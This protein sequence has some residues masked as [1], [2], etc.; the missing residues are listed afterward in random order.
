MKALIFTLALLYL[1]ILGHSQTEVHSPDPEDAESFE[2]HRTSPPKSELI[3]GELNDQAMPPSVPGL[4][5][6]KFCPIRVNEMNLYSYDESQMSGPS[7]WG[8]LNEMFKICEDGKLQ[9]PIN[10]ETDIRTLGKRCG[11]KLYLREGPMRL[12]GLVGNWAFE[13]LEI[14]GCGW[15]DF[16]GRQ[17]MMDSIRFH[18]PSEHYMNGVQYPL[19]AHLE[20]RSDDE[21]MAVVAVLFQFEQESAFL[22]QTSSRVID[23]KNNNHTVVATLLDAVQ[24]GI[25][26]IMVDLSR[27]VSQQHGFCAY[28]G[29]LTTPPCT[30]G[31]D[32]SHVYAQSYRI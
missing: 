28:M 16:L 21:N 19:E 29:S 17:Y 8:R 22:Q 24:M 26:N 32:V 10:F 15:M 14:A 11:A 6:T 5:F 31:G 12:I 18:T 1:L 3:K 20:F 30:E 23:D 9:S 25:E 13:C 2:P 4:S 7:N 27:F